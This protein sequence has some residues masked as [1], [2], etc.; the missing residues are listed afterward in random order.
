MGYVFRADSPSVEDSQ[1]L[2]ALLECQVSL[3]LAFLRRYGNKVP[4][5]YSFATY[6]RTN[7]WLPYPMIWRY[8]RADCK[9]LGPARAAELRLQGINVKM[10]HRWVKRRDGG[11]DFHILLMV[12]G[13]VFEDPSKICGM[14]DE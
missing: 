11:K 7:E 1:A 14:R 4:P 9:S 3:G 8:K 12:N 2:E 6:A 13:K 10:V 5:L